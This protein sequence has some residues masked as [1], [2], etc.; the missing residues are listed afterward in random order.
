M[1]FL[2]LL[3]LPLSAL[4]GSVIGIRNLLF[5][6]GILRIKT[7]DTPVLCVGNITVGGTGKTPHTEL[8]LS[9]LKKKFR[10]A[11]LSRGYKRRTS[12]FILATDTSTARD[13]GDEPKQVKRKFHDIIVA[14][15]ADRVRGIGKLLSLPQKPEVI[16]LDDAFQ[17]RYVKA[18]KNI[19]LMDYHRPVY[20]D[21][22]LPAGRLRE[23]PKALKRAD[24][25]IVTK[26]P[27]NIQPIER[28]IVTKQLKVRPYQQLFFTYM[29][30]GDIH[31]LS[32]AAES[33][34]IGKN[35][36]ILCVTGIAC[37]A[38]YVEH[39][40]KY[41]ADVRELTYPDHHYFSPKDICHIEEVFAGIENKEKYIFTT[42]KDAV[43]FIGEQLPERIKEYIYYIPIVPVFLNKGDLLL[44]ELIEYVG[45]NK[46]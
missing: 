32:G 7:F 40:K 22:L 41:T 26:C 45:K 27:K 3:L 25:I 30:Y 21:S 5:Q 8:I 29:E 9:E 15:D 43:R 2:K 14:C 34:V 46:R 38:P 24:Y 16:L 20:Q 28:R 33:P 6:I 19:V 13:I 35:G 10:V 17:H 42:E 23:K 39:L 36:T 12:G 18:D 11:Y 4:Y 37:P 31:S 1:A 44:N